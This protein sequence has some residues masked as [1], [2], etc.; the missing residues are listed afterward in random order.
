MKL[1]KQDLREEDIPHRT[2]IRASIIAAWQVFFKKLKGELAVRL[3]LFGPN[4]SA[5]INCSVLWAMSL[6]RGTYGRTVECAHFSASHVTGLLEM[7]QLK[8]WN[9]KRRW[10]PSTTWQES[11]TVKI[12]QMF[13]SAFLIGLV[14][15]QMWVSFFV[16]MFFAQLSLDWPFHIRPCIKQWNVD[17]GAGEPSH[18][19]WDFIWC[20]RELYWVRCAV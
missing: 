7:L 4:A 18:L 12:S 10:S 6:L 13:P 15:P 14:L 8:R 3:Y 16:E 9:S 2:K 20:R 17:E 11:T 19:A 5:N 1:L